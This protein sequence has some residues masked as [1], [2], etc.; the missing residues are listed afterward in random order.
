MM[1]VTLSNIYTFKKIT[2]NLLTK[3]KAIYQSLAFVLLVN[4]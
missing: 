4:T 2:F 3:A 1:A